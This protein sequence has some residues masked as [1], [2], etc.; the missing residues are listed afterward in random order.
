[1]SLTADWQDQDIAAY[2]EF[3]DAVQIADYTVPLQV[4]ASESDNKAAAHNPNGNA[5]GIFQLMPATAK[6][7]GYNVRFDPTLAMFRAM[8]VAGQLDWARKF[9]GAHTGQ[10][11]T[12]AS[13][14]LCTFLPAL[15][16][17]AAD[18]THVLA[19]K[20]GPLEWVYTANAASFDPLHTGFITVQSLVDAAARA[21]GPRTHEL[22]DRVRAYRATIT[23]QP[24]PVS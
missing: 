19:A 12:V 10:V 22:M 8:P 7:I 18:P 15:L 24:G 5:S 6:D 17:C 2:V 13:F 23:T 20:G 4:W 14:Y 11:G 3:C 1:M 21:T 9:Y 16:S